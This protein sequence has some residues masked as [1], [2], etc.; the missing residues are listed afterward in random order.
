MKCPKCQAENSDERKF[1]RECGVKLLLMCPQCGSENLP[2]DKFCGECGH[3]L[4]LPPEP[5]PRE[6]SFDEKIE[7][8][9]R[10]LPEGITEKILSQRDKIEGERK[11]VT[12]MFCD[13]EGFT[14]LVE[15]L[16]PEEAYSIMDQVYEILIHKVHD[17]EGTVNEMTGDGIMALFGAPI[18]LEDAPQRAIRSAMAIHREMTSFNERLKKEKG[19][20]P[21]IKMRVGIHTGPVVVGTLGNDLRLEF[22]AVGDTVNLASRME[23]LAEPG[24]TYVSDDTFKLT[25]GFFRFEALGEKEVKGKEK[26]VR[27]YRVIAPTT[28]RTRFDVSAERGLTPF[29]G[30]NRELELLLD[31]VERAKEGT[32]QAFS[33]IG[34]AGVGKSRFLYEFRK[35]VSNEDITFLEGKC[36]SYSKGVSYHPIIDV[37]RGNFDITEHDT[38]DGIREKV[39]TN[40]KILK[41]DEAATLPYLLELLGV[42]ESGIDRLSMSP[43][44]LKERIIESV[45]Q[46]ILKGAQIRPLI[47]AIEDLHWADKSTEDALAF[48]LDAVP[49]TRV[50][51]LFTYRPEFVNTWGGRSYH[52]QITLNRL[53]NRESLVMV[54]HVLGADAADPEFQRLV[55]GKTEGIPF[56]IEEFVKSLQGMGVIKREDG[57]V[58]IEGDT[59]SV[60]IPST[61]QDMIM[62]RVDRL[63]D[64]ARGVIK[65]ASVIEREFPHEL[66][67]AVSGLP[68]TDFI[69]HL[70]ALKDA[71]LL[72]ERGIYPRT[73]YIFRHALTREVVYASILARRRRELHGQIAAAIEEMHK[74]DLAEHYEILCEHFYQSEDYGRAAEYAKR[75]ARKAEKSASLPDAIVH[76]QKRILCLE[77]SLKA[78][79]KEKER[80]DARAA[81]GLYLNQ[82]NHFADAGEAVEPVARLAKG[83]GYRKRLGQIQTI[84]GCYY[85]FVNEDFPKAFDALGEGLR[86]AG[87]ENDFITLIMVSLW[88][89]VFQSFNG[90]FE[91]AEQSIQ[92]AVDINTAARSLWGIASMKAQLAYFSY[93]FMGRI[94]ALTELSSEALEIAQE[95]GDPI[96]KGISHTTY[97]RACFSKGRLQDAETH[98]LNGSELCERVGFYGWAATAWNGLAETYYE[99]KEYHKSRDC[100]AQAIRNC[101]TA[102][103]VPSWVRLSRLGMA[104][105]G[106]M[107]G[108]RDV[109]LEPLRAIPKKNRMKSLE[110]WNCR[111]LGEILLNLGGNHI[112]ESQQWIQKSIEADSKNGMRFHLGLDHALYGEYFKRQGNRTKA[113]DEFRKAIE[114]LLECG[115]DGWV[116][117]YKKELATLSK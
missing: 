7:K 114:V 74:E 21:P 2:S 70:S 19:D 76:A 110:G 53:S 71:E 64:G 105:C 50:L 56:F 42:K 75:S 20:L 9:Q 30:R 69:S 109:N 99:M 83:K 39:R 61:I 18:A 1:C 93:F 91:K 17:Y 67:Q 43:E 85:G 8:I 34:Q 49:G 116:K 29:V 33:I 23:S 63:S 4:T 44:G 96:S 102:R 66:I 65:A 103:S 60:V 57:K 97:G 100:H 24:T 35:E 26:P 25:E 46:I 55:L 104:K 38:D 81:L 80:I 72:Y 78:G 15:S 111:Y 115:A 98:I 89:G 95:S 37:L 52:N 106:V 12:V 48:L 36:L 84:M 62:A 94:N 73:S 6:L 5:S 86:I 68:E 90:D 107:L 108:E 31:G 32:G 28:R 88:F 117:K 113:Q 47:I 87:E 79:E 112:A 41:A 14:S 59:Q 3:N 13:M 45:K 16:G 54:S 82:I 92:K 27:I 101:E 22:K 51:I 11:Q 40:L 10:Y 77:K 58:L